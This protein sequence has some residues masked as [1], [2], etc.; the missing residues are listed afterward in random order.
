MEWNQNETESKQSEHKMKWKWNKNVLKMEQKWNKTEMKHKL[1]YL[2]RLQIIAQTI[3]NFL[4]SFTVSLFHCYLQFLLNWIWVANLSCL[5]ETAIRK[6]LNDVEGLW[7]CY[8]LRKK[9]GPFR[10]SK[11]KCPKWQT[12]LNSWDIWNSAIW[13][14]TKNRIKDY[15][16]WI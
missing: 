6:L 13:K 11:C 8:V 4:C 5:P 2:F 16:H 12:A 1:M 3:L 10:I 14:H 9:E 15:K 7:A